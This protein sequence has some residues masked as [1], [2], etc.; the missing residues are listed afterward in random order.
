MEGILVTDIQVWFGVQEH[1][2]WDEDEEEFEE[3]FLP[4]KRTFRKGMRIRR[5]GKILPDF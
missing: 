5:D 1:V 2:W 4:K 3:R